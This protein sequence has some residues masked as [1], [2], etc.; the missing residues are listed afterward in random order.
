MGLKSLDILWYNLILTKLS[1]KL[2]FLFSF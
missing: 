2:F 1:F